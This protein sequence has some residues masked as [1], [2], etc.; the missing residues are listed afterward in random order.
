MLIC[1]SLTTLK[2]RFVD[3]GHTFKKV[4][5]ESNFHTAEFYKEDPYIRFLL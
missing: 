1:M 5:G 2:W 3:K 4:N